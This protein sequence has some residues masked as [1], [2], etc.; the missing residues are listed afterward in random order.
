M[1]SIAVGTQF[2][3]PLGKG[4]CVYNVDDVLTTTN[5]AGVVVKIEYCASKS[6]INGIRL[7]NMF[8]KVS[9]LRGMRP[10]GDIYHAAV[11]AGY[12]P[13]FDAPIVGT[14]IALADVSQ[15]TQM[16]LAAKAGTRLA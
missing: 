6:Y 7:T 10:A 1:T 12:S 13:Y 11:K 5:L 14:P 15:E 8:N 4:Y 3:Q 16:A 9:V 2:Y